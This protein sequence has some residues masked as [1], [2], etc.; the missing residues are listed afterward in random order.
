MPDFRD[1]NIEELFEKERLEQ[2]K[3]CLEIQ[4]IVL[5]SIENFFYKQGFY[6]M[7]PVILSPITDPLGPDPNASVIKTGE[8]EYNNQTLQLTQSMILHKQIAIG[9]GLEKI[10]AISPNIR[11]E[12]P[13]RGKTGVHLFEFNQVDFEIVNAKM[14]DVFEFMEKLIRVIKNDV[15]KHA[16]SS[17]AF[18][19]RNFPKWEHKFPI[20]STHELKEKYGDDWEAKASAEHKSPF[21]VTDHDREFYDKQDRSC[22]DPHFLNYDLY[23]GEGF[24]EALSGAEREYEYEF[25]LKRIEE[26]QLPKAKYE[27]F[28]ELAKESKLK[29]SAGAGFGVERLLRYLTGVDH[30]GL[31]QMFPRVPGNFQ[32][33]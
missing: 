12:Y 7:L 33:Y 30:I 17:L 16:A 2:I 19:D 20:Y 10:Y 4:R 24:G 29:P 18:F 25:I 32:R 21:W 9:H 23:Y 15:K 26:D 6:K 14:V 3:H 28:I 22:S 5:H 13:E 31:V 11:L 1:R 8:I 27:Q